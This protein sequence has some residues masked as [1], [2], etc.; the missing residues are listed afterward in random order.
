ML[1]YR[2]NRAWTVEVVFIVLQQ[3]EDDLLKSCFLVS[4]ACSSLV[5]TPRIPAQLYQTFRGFWFQC[6]KWH[7]KWW[8]GENCCYKAVCTLVL[9]TNQVCLYC[10]PAFIVISQ[11]LCMHY[12]YSDIYKHLLYLTC[13]WTVKSERHFDIE[14][15]PVNTCSHTHMSQL[16][17]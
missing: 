10:G 17:T 5:C 4:S 9:C 6:I 11:R 16:H 12:M 14:V 7:R 3:N 13:L 8:P 1:R 15:Q 2:D